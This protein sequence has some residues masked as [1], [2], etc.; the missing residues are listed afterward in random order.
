MVYFFLGINK[1]VDKNLRN[2]VNNIRTNGYF[3]KVAKK[4]IFFEIV[5]FASDVFVSKNRPKGHGI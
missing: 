3:C 4:L 2:H 1:L 5:R